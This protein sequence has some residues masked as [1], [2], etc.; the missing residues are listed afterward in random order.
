MTNKDLT[1]RLRQYTPELMTCQADNILDACERYRECRGRA[2]G[3]FQRVEEYLYERRERTQ[4]LLGGFHRLQEQCGALQGLEDVTRHLE[5]LLATIG[6][7][8]P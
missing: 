2:P 5:G 4:R 1:M 6:E 7:V 8:L 3:K